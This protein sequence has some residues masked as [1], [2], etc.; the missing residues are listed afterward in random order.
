MSNYNTY[1]MQYAQQAFEKI[2]ENF[3]EKSKSRLDELEKN[4]FEINEVLE[5]I[6]RIKTCENIFNH[7]STLNNYI[8]K[9]NDNFPKIN[10][11][12]TRI[13][14]FT[15]TPSTVNS[16]D[17]AVKQGNSAFK[18]YL[19]YLRENVNSNF[20][21]IN[22][23]KSFDVSSIKKSIQETIDDLDRVDEILSK[24][25][26]YTGIKD[27]KKYIYKTRNTLVKFKLN[28]INIEDKWTQIK[29]Y[30]LK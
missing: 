12:C 10:P 11:N 9:L 23:D 29:V 27:L 19:V 2:Q 5:G 1:G 24:Q 20:S 15:Y 22:N 17:D 8:S 30:E 26:G 7:K 18:K 13:N 6:Y 28:I 3:V 25:T 14:S 16:Y 21:L 4:V